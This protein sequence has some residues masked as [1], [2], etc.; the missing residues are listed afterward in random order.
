LSAIAQ[1][2]RLPIALKSSDPLIPGFESALGEFV[3]N[4]GIETALPEL[5]PGNLGGFL[6]LFLMR[7]GFQIK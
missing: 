1:K 5:F 6:G 4:I 7:I 2:S 3:G